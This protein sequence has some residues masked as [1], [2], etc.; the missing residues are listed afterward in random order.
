MTHPYIAEGSVP[1]GNAALAVGPCR[2]LISLD[3]DGTLQNPTGPPIEPAFFE[4][5]QAWRHYGVRWGINTGRTL[6]YLLQEI[7]PCSPVLP[8]FICTCERY[9]YLADTRGYLQPATKHNNECHLHNLA[10]RELLTPHLHQVLSELHHSHPHLHW[11]IATDDPLSVEAT[12]STTMDAI[13]PHLSHLV[14]PACTIQ[15]AGRYM[16]FADSRHTKG[17]A[18][19]YVMHAWN[20]PAEHVFIMGDGHND[21]D[22][23]SRFP[24]A[25]CAAPATAHSEVLAWLANHP[26]PH[27]AAEPGVLPELR[28]WF[29]AQNM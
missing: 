9:V 20:V 12:D 1:P 3:Y 24:T 18:L 11:Q 16:R 21:I 14:S 22:A 15:R 6:D 13:I 29:T 28:R 23:F 25:W 2:R 27:I 7:L 17:T 26:N 8:D 19:G 5:M 4:Q 10:L